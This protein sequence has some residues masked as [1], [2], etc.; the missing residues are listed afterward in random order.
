MFLTFPILVIRVNTIEKIVE[1]RWRNMA[2]RRGRQL[3]SSPSSGAGSSTPAGARPGARRH[4]GATAGRRSASGSLDEPADLAGRCWPSWPLFAVA[5]PFLFS[6]YQIEHHDHRPDLRDAGPGA[7]HRRRPGRAAR[8]G[9]RRLLRR[10]APTPTP[11]STT[12]SASASGP[13]L[14]VGG[15]LGA[16]FGILLG[17]PVLRLRGDYLAIVTLGFGEIIRLILENWNAF[18][19]GPSGIANI[20]RPGLFGIG[21][22]RSTRRPSTSTTS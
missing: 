12:I 8:S 20:P 3:S 15:L 9:L 10:R 22:R 6:S 17:F 5:F 16:L 21:P 7:E 14:P 1:W 19:F 2:L 13:C 11:C 4:G 18:S